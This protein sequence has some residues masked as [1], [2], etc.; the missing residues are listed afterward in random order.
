MCLPPLD[1]D[2]DKNGVPSDHMIVFMKP[3]DAINNNPARTKKA[4]TF[5]PLPESG[6]SEMGNWIVSYNW[7]D[8]FN[9]ETAHAKAEIFQMTLIEKLNYF[10]PEKTVKFTSEDQVWVTPEIKEMSRKKY[11]EFYKH[12][13]SSK[14]KILNTQFE[15]KCE[16]ARKAYYTNIVSDHKNSN[17]GQWYSKVNR[18]SSYDQLKSEQVNIE[19]ICNFKDIEH[20][21]S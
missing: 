9:A 10:L 8:V 5:R 15:E 7:D 11:R 17:P 4:V 21:S 1:N 18:M 2:P 19:N 6:I 12:R 16:L 13:K 20:D 14:W 3:I